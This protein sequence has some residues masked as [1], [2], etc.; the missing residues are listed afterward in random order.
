M[1]I[2]FSESVISRSVNSGSVLVLRASLS[3]TT[4]TDL[5]N[6]EPLITFLPEGVR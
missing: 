2:V 5:L 1:K 6:T 4:A 3:R